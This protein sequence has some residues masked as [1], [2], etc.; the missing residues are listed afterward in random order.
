MVRLHLRDEISALPHFDDPEHRGLELR[1][2][3]G[4]QE[5]GNVNPSKIVETRLYEIAIGGK[6]D[7][8]ASRWKSLIASR[9][10]EE[11]EVQVGSNRIRRT[12]ERV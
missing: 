2:V 12:P 11:V 9:V 1:G 6:I 10:V 5:D 7:L 4:V 8:T 3:N